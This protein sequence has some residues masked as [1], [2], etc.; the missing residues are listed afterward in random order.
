MQITPNWEKAK[1]VTSNLVYV[2][3]LGDPGGIAPQFCVSPIQ[4]LSIEYL[5]SN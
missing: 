5:C 2:M 4:L 3:I 1:P